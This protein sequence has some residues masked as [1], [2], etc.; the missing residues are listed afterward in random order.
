MQTRFPPPGTNSA[1]V[2]GPLTAD[3]PTRRERQHLFGPRRLPSAIRSAPFCDV[4]RCRSGTVLAG[5]AGV[6]VPHNSAVTGGV[7]AYDASMTTAHIS[8]GDGQIAET[9]LLPGDPL[10]AK[11]IAE[12][13]LDRAELVT[14]V[15]NIFG[16]TGD[17][18]GN[19]VSVMGTGMGIPSISIYATELARF[20]GVKRLLRIG[21][22]GGLQDNVQLGDVIV[23]TGASTDSNVNRTRM[24]GCDL[25]A[26]PDFWLTRSLVDAATAGAGG[27]ATVHVG[28][29]LTSDL[30]Y[31]PEG[32]KFALAKRLGH[33][34][35]EMEAA[36]LFGV[37]AEDH[38]AT[39][40]L[41]TVS[42]HLTT[43]EKMSVEERERGFASMVE[44]ALNGLFPATE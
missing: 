8:A 17:V 14:S 10:R 22:C 18:R 41:L 15:R 13:F 38:V 24:G 9:I 6:G 21:S 2:S 23:V 44:I 43:H 30:F 25:A 34:A 39:A 37:G 28:A 27:S 40:A 5:N 4:E 33:L 7:I 19:R 1:P 11:W 42:D 32:E 29:V 35:V 36:G 20:L 16:Y 3:A 31:E 26:V 12:N